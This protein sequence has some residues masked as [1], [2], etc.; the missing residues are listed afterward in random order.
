[1]SSLRIWIA[2]CRPKTLVAALVP[3]AIGGS[4]YWAYGD[5]NQAGQPLAYLLTLLCCLGFAFGAQIVSNFA[6]DLGDAKR[7]ADTSA[8]VGPQRAV[9]SGLL[10]PRAMKVGILLAAAFAC[11]AGLIIGLA[12]PW[13]FIAG[14][15]ALVLAMAYTLGPYPLAYL[16]LGDVFVVGC[17]GLQAT[18]LTAYALNVIVPD[19]SCFTM[20]WIPALLAGLGVGL[21]ADN[22][23]LANNAR[24]LETDLAAGKRTTVVRFGHGFA[25]GL[26]LFNLAVGLACLG[27]VFGWMPLL[28]TPFAL[29]Q[30][31]GFRQARAP[32]DFVP[33]L[34]QAAL[35]LLIAGALCVTAACFDLTPVG[36][37]LLR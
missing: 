21:L 5:L 12:E 30:H 6:N 24:D 34:A 17:F 31:R 36:K 2:A 29:W 11:L 18:A 1:M 27:L 23:L 3:V 35:L 32:T 8:R 33:F 14:I 25:R 9:S 37:L 20:P 19:C 16:G 4:V 13:L 15:L 26:H 28:A 7:G 22:I 10:S